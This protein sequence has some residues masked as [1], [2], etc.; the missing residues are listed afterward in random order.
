MTCQKCGRDSGCLHK[1]TISN[2]EIYS[3]V[4]I[5]MILSQ[6][7]ASLFE[8]SILLQQSTMYFIGS[9]VL[10][11]IN[12]LLLIS[13]Y[14]FHKQY[15]ALFYGC[16]QKKERS[17]HI[18]KTPFI[19]CSR[20]MGILIGIFFTPIV[21]LLDVHYYYLLLLMIPLLVD[22]LLQYLTTYQSNH[23]KRI[24]TGF[25]FSFGFVFVF[26]LITSYGHYVARLVALLFVN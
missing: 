8:T 14:F 7:M 15:I 25:L 26:G 24:T 11:S 20:C 19:L 6:G 17:I 22:G 10:I 12:L 1:E 16:H 2:K 21:L 23:F 4:A 18:K 9:I 5:I 13:Y 3:I